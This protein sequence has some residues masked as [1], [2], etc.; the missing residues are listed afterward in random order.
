MIDLVALAHAQ[1]LLHGFE[2]ELPKAVPIAEPSHQGVRDLRQLPWSSIDNRES[3]DLDQVEVAERLP[4]GR[5]K[6]LVGI[7]DVDALVAKGSPLDLRSARNTTSV[8]TGVVTFPML[9]EVLSTDRTSLNQDED[10]LAIVI[11][12]VVEPD[13]A[14]SSSD[15]Y[16][17]LLRN[18]ARLSYEDLGDWLAGKAPQPAGL[19]AQIADQLE[20]QDAATRKLLARRLKNGALQLETIEAQAVAKD[21]RVLDVRVTPK[22]RSRELIEDL[23]IAANGAMAQFLDGKKISS[24]RRVVK[25]PERW[26]RIVELAQGMGEALPAQPS[27][28][29]LAALLEKRR[30]AD[31]AHFADLSLAIVKLL[32]PGETE[33]HRPGAETSGHFGLAVQDYTHST[34]PNRRFA[35]LVTQRLVKAALATEPAP[36][37]DAELAAI[38]QRC[39]L[40]EGDARK[41]ERF[42]RKAAAAV[43]LSGRIGET[44]DAIVTGASAKGVFVRLLKPPAEG[45]VTRN[46]R[47][48]DVG[49]QVKVKLLLADPQRA[50]IDF[51]RVL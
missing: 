27:A 23:M 11:E 16:R 28:P 49:A 32:G 9:P 44:F 42:M 8:Y 31:P 2:P 41:L 30:V 10:R 26:S 19:A 33:L 47:G 48:L 40:K 12:L 3:R 15:V 18:H 36:Y 25:E 50:F 29:A 22:S 1:M 35:D 13:G 7:A 20:L 17:A 51:E 37:T 46:E 6:L 38:A 45:R 43:L 21:G 4:G 14:V 5:V 34:A 24:L 39:N